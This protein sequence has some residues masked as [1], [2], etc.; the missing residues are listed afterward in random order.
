MTESIDTLDRAEPHVAWDV[1]RVAAFL[2]GLAA[3]WTYMPAAIMD[4]PVLRVVALL[5]PAAV[6]LFVADLIRGLWLMYRGPRSPAE[7]I[8][9]TA[10]DFLLVIVIVVFLPPVAWIYNGVQRLRKQ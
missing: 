9:V 3:G 10:L 5:V 6:G 8:E 4:L 7:Q 2:L 1:L